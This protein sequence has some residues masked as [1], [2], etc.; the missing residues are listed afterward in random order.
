MSKPLIQVDNLAK[1]Y[2]YHEIF[3]NIS[4]LIREGERIALVGPNGVGKSTV[5]KILA[6][7]ESADNGTITCFHQQLTIS[8]V[9]QEPDFGSAGSPWEAL[10][11]TGEA[12]SRFGFTKVEAQLPITALSGGQKTRLALARAWL[13]RPELLLL[14]EPTNHLDQAGLEW[15]TKFVKTYSGTVLVVSHDRYFLDSV[16]SRVIELA[17]TQAREYTG[18][19][20]DYRQAKQAAYNQ[21]MARYQGEQKR[22]RRIE[23]SIQQQLNWFARS[24]RA[25]G[26]DD[27]LRARSKRLAKTAK[28]RIKRL[29]A[30]KQSSVERPKEEAKVYLPGFSNRSAGRRIIHAQELTHSFEKQLFKPSNFSVSRGDK[31][32]IV[33]PNGC[34]KTTLLNLILGRLTPIGGD[35]WV[36]PGAKIGYLDQ[37]LKELNPDETVLAEVLKAFGLHTSEAITR[38]RTLLGCFLFSADDIDKPIGVLSTG[39]RK[40]VALVKLLISSFNLLILDEP[41]DHLDLP[42]RE[43]LEEVLIA[44]Q[45]TLLLVSHDRYLREKVCTNNLV[46]KDQE[47]ISDRGQAEK[48]PNEDD[49]FLLRLKLAQLDA[50]L[51]AMSREDPGYQDR[52]REYFAVAEKLWG[53][54]G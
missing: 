18:N 31:V 47:I 46:F 36:S 4:F 19:Y 5:L 8:Y 2:G 49:Q 14:D 29:E 27:F 53:R 45:G 43:V 3:T 50:E 21:Q 39:E 13:S 25:A 20:T 34:G 16:V 32:G 42:T 7:L 12:I 40:R 22:I 28:A 33:G 6:N 38:A 30:M 37:E 1:S 41:T 11:G 35:L 54:K 51:T 10:L 9:P 44:Y 52:E 26:Q 23:D 17:P 48:E 15:L 24:H